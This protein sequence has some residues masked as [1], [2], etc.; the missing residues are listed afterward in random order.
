MAMY[1]NQGYC[2]NNSFG[3]TEI[4]AG[5]GWEEVKEVL[6]ARTEYMVYPN[7]SNNYAGCYIVP[8]FKEG[9]E[10]ARQVAYKLQAF[11][12]ECIYA[13]KGKKIAC[14][15][16]INP[17][18]IPMAIGVNGNGKWVLCQGVS[19]AYA[20]VAENDNYL[21]AMKDEPEQVQIFIYKK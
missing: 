7:A 3:S 4:P 16:V 6:G 18:Q 15:D 17:Y 1:E 11:I 2:P 8:M 13:E 12:P 21:I 9:D 19:K 10:V 14:Y 5:D 20:F